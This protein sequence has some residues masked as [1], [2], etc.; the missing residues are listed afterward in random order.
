MIHSIRGTVIARNP[1]HVVVECGGVG[2]RLAVSAETQRQVP[3]A[4][5]EAIL[6]SHLIIRDD[7]MLL[8]GFATQEERDLFLMLIGV[9]SV[10]PKVALAVL[11]GGTPRELL[12]ALA[13]GDT[14][15]F[16][17]VPG[18]GKRTA[19]RIIVELREKVAD[20]Q[21]DEIII[22]RSDDPHTIARQGLVGLG[23]SP[24]EADGLLDRA[25]GETPEEL[26]AGAL[27][28]AR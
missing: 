23:F 14:A 22:T 24:E 2:Y 7:S 11:S 13:A 6:H 25:E 21:L 16:Q 26:I 19:E 10:G 8:F 17:A 3:G 1:D 4:G 28:A 5:Q 9:Q 27:K 15:R 20:R 18:I 12:N